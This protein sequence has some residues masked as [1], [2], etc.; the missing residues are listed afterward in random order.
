MSL[1]LFC[2]AL[3][4]RGKSILQLETSGEYGGKW[5]TLKLD[6]IICV[7]NAEA[8]TSRFC[9]ESINSF[10]NLVHDGEFLWNQSCFPAAPLSSYLVDLAP[11]LLLCSGPLVSL[12][13]ESGAH[14]YVEF[15]HVDK[16]F[17][18]TED[19]ESSFRW[20]IVPSTRKDIFLDENLKPDQKRHL[21]RFINA[22]GKAVQGE[23]PL[24]DLINS[25]RSFLS[26]M[27][28]YDLDDHLQ[29]SI[30]Y[31][32]LLQT[33]F[34]AGKIPCFKAFDI[35]NDY[36][37]S[38]GRFGIDSGPFLVPMYGCCELSQSFSRAAAVRGA[39]QV[40]RCPVP[41][42]IFD[43]H[44]YRYEGLQLWNNQVVNFDTLIGSSD[45]LK[46]AVHVFKIP[47]KRNIMHRC[48]L[49]VDSPLMHGVEQGLAIIP[50]KD[51]LGSCVFV[52]QF[53]SGLSMCPKGEWLVHLW[54]I[55]PESNIKP[56]HVGRSKE[57]LWPIAKNMVNVD[58]LNATPSILSFYENGSYNCKKEVKPEKKD[59]KPIAV[60]ALFFSM[61]IDDATATNAI[62]N[63]PS[64][65]HICNGP[66]GAL[67]FDNSIKEALK[68]YLKLSETEGEKD[69]P[70]TPDRIRQP[71]HGHEETSHDAGYE[72]EEEIIQA[73]QNALDLT[74]SK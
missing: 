19:S 9:E 47:L 68:S 65:I 7:I 55:E 21:M 32:V 36:F 31:G 43:E 2:S 57:V 24:K 28:E 69:F 58:G 4:E 17:I 30:V 39:I 23:G 60:M 8:S 26:L 37:K 50:S 53:G 45:A 72:S 48:A 73:L 52:M 35:L 67:L 5:S 25:D 70:F 42:F 49:V 1:I 12:L 27:D 54:C 71:S 29:N 16:T 18:L 51:P 44:R 38:L 33:E 41:G 61:D 14:N 13:L 3:A 34:N 46:E 59:G 63:C 10:R 22:C 66:S 20:Q 56:R 11:H 62:S 64:N 74:D 40:L 15:K 6:E